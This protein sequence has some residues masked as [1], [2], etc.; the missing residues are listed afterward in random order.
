MVLECSRIAK[1]EKT[2]H[3]TSSKNTMLTFP[4][5]KKPKNP[6]F[7]IKNTCFYVLFLKELNIRFGE[8]IV[9]KLHK[10]A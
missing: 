8:L 10:L 2:F 4:L 3:K 6:H 7:N 9:E 1:T 5:L